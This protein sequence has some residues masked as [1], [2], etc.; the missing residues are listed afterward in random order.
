MKGKFANNHKK[1]GSSKNLNLPW[2]SQVLFSE[3]NN[4]TQNQERKTLNLKLMIFLK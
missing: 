3:N 4:W 1:I 2:N